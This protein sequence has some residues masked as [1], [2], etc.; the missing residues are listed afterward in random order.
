MHGS[1]SRQVD[2]HGQIC[3]EVAKQKPM[4][5]RVGRSSSGPVCCSRAVVGRLG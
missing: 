2:R 1:G 3:Q 5:L 4:I